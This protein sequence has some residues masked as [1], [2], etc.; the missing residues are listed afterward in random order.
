MVITLRHAH[1]DSQSRVE[2]NSILTSINEIWIGSIDL[3]TSYKSSNLD[4]I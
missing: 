1:N 3:N 2:S 4:W